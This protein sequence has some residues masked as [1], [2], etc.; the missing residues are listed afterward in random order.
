MWPPSLCQTQD[1]RLEQ[2]T[3]AEE[4]ESLHDASLYVSG[5]AADRSNHWQLYASS[6][7]G[8]HLGCFNRL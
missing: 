4:N 6:T 7:P 5:V 8:K 3:Q 1:R 2:P